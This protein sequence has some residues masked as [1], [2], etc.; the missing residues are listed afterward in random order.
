MAT[1]E[2]QPCDNVTYPVGSYVN[3][4]WLNIMNELVGHFGFGADVSALIWGSVPGEV[5][6]AAAL[7]DFARRAHSQWKSNNK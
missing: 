2:G 5:C 1:F 7:I 3:D 4:E 6:G